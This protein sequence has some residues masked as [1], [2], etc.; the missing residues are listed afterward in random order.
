[1]R[2]QTALV[3]FTI[4]AVTAMG[5]VMFTSSYAEQPASNSFT[6]LGAAAAPAAGDFLLVAPPGGGNGGFKG[7]VYKGGGKHFHSGSG[8]RGW[9]W[10]YYQGD[11]Y[12]YQNPTCWWNGYKFVCN[13]NTNDA[14]DVY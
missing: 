14:Y 12:Y 9:Y 2:T 7:G 6:L 4:S 3:V 13:N 10:P 11:F 5:L 8:Y 1:M